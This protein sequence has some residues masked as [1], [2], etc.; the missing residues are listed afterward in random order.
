MSLPSMEL[1]FPGPL[2]DKLVAAV[3]DGSKTSTTGLLA[4]YEVCGE[5][6]PRKGE[7]LGLVDSADDVI[8]VVEIT[9]VR[10]CRLSEVDIQHVVDEGEGDTT[11][12]TWRA[13]HEKFFASK[14]MRD[15]LGDPGFTV[16][17]DTLVVL[18][19]FRVVR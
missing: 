17:D 15:A 7:R 1:E 5:P 2:R 4:D 16:D 9:E 18:Q 6:L 11:Y 13:T 19:R 8:A 12:A 10:T 3:L 14:E